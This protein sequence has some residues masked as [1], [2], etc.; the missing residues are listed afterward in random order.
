MLDLR[1]FEPVEQHQEAALKRPIR[2]KLFLKEK[3]DS[4]G[5]SL[6]FKARLVA[7]GHMQ[8]RSLLLPEEISS[9]TAPTP[10]IFAVASIAAAE[11]RSVA[12]ADVPGAYLHADISHQN[13]AMRLDNF[14]TSTIIQ[15]HPE[16]ERFRR[17][18]GTLTVKLHRALYGCVESGKLWYD[19]LRAILEADGFAANPI[20]PCI[21]N[22]TVNG[23]QIT[24][25]IYVDDLL[26]TSKDDNMI[27]ST[28]T[29]LSKSLSTELKLKRG[30]IH[31]YLGM[32][33]DFSE[34]KKCKI[35]MPAYTADILADTGITSSI[36]SPAASHLFAVREG[37]PKLSYDKSDKFHSLVAKCSYMAKRTRPDIL[38][39]VSFLSTRVQSPDEDDWS[40]LLRVLKYLCATP[41][42]GIALQCDDPINIQSYI[43]AS[44]APHS[45]FRS[46]TGMVVSLGRGPIDV[47]STKQKINTKSSAEAELIALS[48]KASHVIWCR[49]FLIAQGHNIPAAVIH[50]D[51]QSTITLA[52]NGAASSDRTRHVSIRHY[53]LKDRINSNEIEVVYRPTDE[54]IA[55][56]LT[57]PLHGDKFVQLRDLLLNWKL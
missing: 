29:H 41:S 39:P 18:D 6:G 15:L 30:S 42:L 54:M 38:L 10:F 36:D 17:S 28:V 26:L 8:D 3:F 25:V 57:K 12:T 55:D 4:N 34:S 33:W 1:V 37:A 14:L 13:I 24:V 45:D 19:K 23:I 22:K 16:W 2:S 32:T 5:T 48:D 11:G 53:W 52:S 9:P 20:A 46:H 49:E 51:N 31:S 27:Q 50:Q 21:M 56:I 44:Y 43:D 7:G 40:K 35:S 47:A